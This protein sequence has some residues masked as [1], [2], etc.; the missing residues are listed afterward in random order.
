MSQLPARGRLVA[1]KARRS[2][3]VSVTHRLKILW[4]GVGIVAVA[5]LADV[6]VKTAGLAAL[7]K[8]PAAVPGPPS[9]AGAG[10]AMVWW[11]TQRFLPQTLPEF[12]LRLGTLAG[13]LR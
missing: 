12:A 9:G 8:G 7:A 1:E 6:G 5:L 2:V 10:L 3:R 13:S 4:I 11:I